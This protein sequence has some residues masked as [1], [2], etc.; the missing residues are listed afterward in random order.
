MRCRL[1]SL[2]L[3]RGESLQVFAFS[4]ALLAGLRGVMFSVLNLRLMERLR[5]A[6]G[7]TE[8]LL[9]CTIACCRL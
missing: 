8:R 3:P 4:Y 1:L 9:H 7:R 6:A 2:R 5:R